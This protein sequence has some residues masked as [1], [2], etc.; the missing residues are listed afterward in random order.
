MKRW[1]VL[2][3]ALYGIIL[4]MLSLPLL[5]VF[6]L[7]H[8][9]K[10]GWHQG[11]EASELADAYS[12]WGF[13]LWLAVLLA[14]QALLLLV[15]MDI[16]RE[17]PVQRRR[18]RVPVI[19]TAFFLG[20]LFLAGVISVLCAAFKDEGFE[21]IAWP[22]STAHAFVESFPPLKAAFTQ[23]GLG[24]NESLFIWA[25]LLGLVAV[26]WA[27]WGMIFHHYAKADDAETL[28]QRATRWLLRGSIL[29]FLIAVPSHIIVRQREHCC[30][31]MGTFW[32]M[33]TGLAIMVLAF[34]PGVFYLFAQRMGR[35]RPKE[36]PPAEA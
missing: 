24:T 3:V 29:E 34:G 36:K 8:D 4:V 21:W 18:L 5:L 20:N 12:S 27:I 2:T 23:A 35:L 16:A 7:E 17:R 19:T 1:A 22:G 25:S 31:P 9:T 13:Y 6:G 32:G 10:Q 26:M 28:V 14:G 15:P 33:T 11:M 30:A